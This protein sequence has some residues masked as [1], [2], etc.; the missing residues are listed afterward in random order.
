MRPLFFIPTLVIAA[1]FVALAITASAMTGPAPENIGS[2]E[3]FPPAI[4]LPTGVTEPSTQPDAPLSNKPADIA[5]VDPASPPA[6]S[7]SA[8]D[9]S[10]SDPSPE[11]PVVVSPPGGGAQPSP[12]PTE[13]AKPAPGTRQDLAPIEKIEVSATK[14]LPPQYRAHVTYGLPSGCAKPGGYDVVRKGNVFEITVWNY[15]PSEP[16]PCTMIYGIASHSIPL[17]SDLTTGD[18]YTIRV[19][20]THEKQFT[21]W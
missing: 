17:G 3:P 1:S 5:P 18:T 4:D 9:P 2:P 10:P 21:A 16:T 13:P 8:P 19:N 20:G 12:K 15:M 6:T 7:W 11:P 14:S